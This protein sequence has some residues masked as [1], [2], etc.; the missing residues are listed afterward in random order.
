MLL[1]ADQLDEDIK[2]ALAVVFRAN[3]VDEVNEVKMAD[4]VDEVDEV[5]N[6]DIV[7]VKD[8]IGLDLHQHLNLQQNLELRFSSTKNRSKFNSENSLIELLS[9]AYQ[10]NKT[11]NSIINAKRASLQKLPPDLAKQGIKLAMGDLTLKGNGKSTRLY[12]KRKMYA[13]ENLRLFLL[14]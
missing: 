11:V 10:N 3:K 13:P 6:K 2:K 12:M 14:Q 7:D 5:E 4:E 9:K 8:Y 1:K